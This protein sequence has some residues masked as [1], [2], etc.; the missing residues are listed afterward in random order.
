MVQ[1]VLIPSHNL[2][3]TLK[4]DKTHILALFINLEQAL[5]TMLHNFTLTMFIQIEDETPLHRLENVLQILEIIWSDSRLGLAE[6]RKTPS[7]IS[8]I[9]HDSFIAEYQNLYAG[10]SSQDQITQRLMSWT[11]SISSHLYEYSIYDVVPSIE[12]PLIRNLDLPSPSAM[13]LS[14]FQ[15]EIQN[16]VNTL[17]F[18][19]NVDFRFVPGLRPL[20]TM[21]HGIFPERQVDDW[22]VL[23]LSQW[24][25]QLSGTWNKWIWRGIELELNSSMNGE[26]YSPLVDEFCRMVND[27]M[28]ILR[29]FQWGED[30]QERI[31][32]RFIGVV[33]SSLRMYLL[34]LEKM[35]VIECTVSADKQFVSLTDRDG[36]YLN[37]LCQFHKLLSSISIPTTTEIASQIELILCF[38]SVSSRDAV[39][40]EFRL[41][42]SNGHVSPPLKLTQSHYP[43]F[44]PRVLLDAN[45]E[46][47]EIE[48]YLRG[49]YVQS[50][51]LNLW[52]EDEFRFCA[53]SFMQ[54]QMTFIQRRAKEFAK[55]Q[56]DVEI[57]IMSSMYNLGHRIA[58]SSIYS[59][60]AL[61]SRSSWLS[62]SNSIAES[63]VE[64]RMKPLLD[65]L[66]LNLF[67]LKTTVDTDALGHLG[68]VGTRLF[69]DMAE[70]PWSMGNQD[71]IMVSLV[72]VMIL[73]RVKIFLQDK[74]LHSDLTCMNTMLELVKAV[75]YCADET[76]GQ[77][78]GL[79]M[80]ELE[81]T[82]HCRV[83]ALIWALNKVTSE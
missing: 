64:S 23:I 47:V 6:T 63:D 35:L 44:K 19:P 31:W 25:N 10:I 27:G 50:K 26:T 34:H 38:E 16:W 12:H 15:A 76:T 3:I 49:I 80:R 24:I 1:E 7:T 82:L 51:T 40:V 32:R 45:V 78:Q 43:T 66:D 65:Y 11:E 77:A 42:T 53:V 70:I 56:Q 36:F 72:W 54:G 37:T 69:Y 73:D 61:T 33:V 83:S 75:F 9:I 14:S 5:C 46:S 52:T 20:K 68:R 79:T 21:L 28:E 74:S 17:S 71:N 81:N 58:L 4:S 8:R 39:D 41:N 30:V 2:P 57:A 67:R 55:F 22:F 62:P 60:S 29:G 59:L 18:T 13:I 48:I